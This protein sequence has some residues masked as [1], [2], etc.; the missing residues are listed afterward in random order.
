M[1]IRQEFDFGKRA[2]SVAA[3]TGEYVWK[4]LSQ[5]WLS[6][7][8]ATEGDL[9]DLLTRHAET[10]ET[11]TFESISLTSGLWRSFFRN[12]SGKLPELRKVRFYGNFKDRSH[13]PRRAATYLFPKLDASPWVLEKSAKSHGLRTLLQRA[14]ESGYAFPKDDDNIL[15]LLLSWTRMDHNAGLGSGNDTGKSL[16]F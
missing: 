4:E 15:Y 1:E 6:F 7:L 13:D 12:L 5:L 8:N 10:L 3:L 9:L 11:V 16:G 2:C 14:I